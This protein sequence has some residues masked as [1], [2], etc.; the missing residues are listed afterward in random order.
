MF[1]FTYTCGSVDVLEYQHRSTLGNDIIH[2]GADIT[3]TSNNHMDVTLPVTTT[4]RHLQ[5]AVSDVPM[6]LSSK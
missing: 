2:L 4:G 3:S 5:T 6:A 1:G